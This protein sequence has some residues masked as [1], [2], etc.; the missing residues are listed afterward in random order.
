[1]QMSGNFPLKNLVFLNS[2]EVVS[3][4]ALPVDD[5]GERTEGF[6]FEPIEGGDISVHAFGGALFN[7]RLQGIP[8]LVR[9]G[10]DDEAPVPVGSLEPV[11]G[12][13]FRATWRAPSGPQIQENHLASEFVE[14]VRRVVAY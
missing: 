5:N 9:Q 1:M 6:D 8:R 11:Q 13:K 12:G 3:N 14:M 7:E 2:E 4:H 10:H